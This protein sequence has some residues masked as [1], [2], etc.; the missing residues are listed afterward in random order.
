MSLKIERNGL[1]SW[2]NKRVG[3]VEK[4]GRGYIFTP[5]DDGGRGVEHASLLSFMREKLRRRFLEKELSQ[6]KQRADL[7]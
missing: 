3:R 7:V 4:I 1:A 2:R 5:N 6:T